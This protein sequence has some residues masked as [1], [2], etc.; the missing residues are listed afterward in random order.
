MRGGACAEG[1]E[2]PAL[3]VFTGE[4]IAFSSLGCDPDS[5]MWFE[6]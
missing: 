5:G 2:S 6:D 1:L 4:F 3:S